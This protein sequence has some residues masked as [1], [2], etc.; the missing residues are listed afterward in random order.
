MTATFDPSTLDLLREI[1]E[2]EIETRTAPGAAS[3]RTIIWVVADE[4]DRVFIRSVRGPAARWYREAVA[5]PPCVLHADA[6]ALTVLAVAATDD[7]QVAAC[8]RALPAKYGRGPSV[9]A[10][11]RPAVLPTTLRLVPH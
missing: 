8:S 2:V 9:Q 6:L 1:E 5:N 3:H 10:M 4:E 7:A 11:L